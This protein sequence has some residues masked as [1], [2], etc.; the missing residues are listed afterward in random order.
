MHRTK[1]QPLS[2]PNENHHRVIIKLKFFTFYSCLINTSA[3]CFYIHS[4]AFSPHIALLTWQDQKLWKGDIKPCLDLCG[5]RS[6]HPRGK[7][8]DTSTFITSTGLPIGAQDVEQ[9]S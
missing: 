9:Y 3:L 4:R 2:P 7:A 6:V 1:K 5:E 8:D